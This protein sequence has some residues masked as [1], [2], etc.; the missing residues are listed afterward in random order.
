[1]KDLGVEQFAAFDG[2]VVSFGTA[3]DTLPMKDIV[4]QEIC[5]RLFVSGKIPQGST[6]GDL[7]R[8]KSCAVAWEA[9]Q[10][11]IIFESEQEH[12]DWVAANN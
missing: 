2:K 12:C 11:V 4:F 6:V 3:A 7:A 5:G 9:V 1:M 10:E 8:G